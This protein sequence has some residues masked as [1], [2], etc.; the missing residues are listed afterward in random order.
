[1]P[2]SKKTTKH[3]GIGDEAVL[4]KTGKSWNEWF[5]ILDAMKAKSLPHKEIASFL[6]KKQGLSPWWSQMITVG[7]EQARGLREKHETSKGFV[8]NIS[9]TILV[10]SEILYNMWNDSKKRKRWLPDDFSITKATSN[11][12]LRIKWSEPPTIV[13]VDFYAKSE[14]KSQLVVQ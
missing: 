5:T 14:S 10:S 2:T 1:M 11:K 9:K 4:S 6:N 12:S 13:C 3:A 7:Y 8:A